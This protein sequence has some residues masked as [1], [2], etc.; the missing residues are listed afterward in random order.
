MHHEVFQNM[1][2]TAHRNLKGF[3]LGLFATVLWGSYYP[4]AR[5]IFGKEADS[6]DPFLLSL[7]RFCFCVLFFLPFVIGS[8]KRRAELPRLIRKEWKMLI[9]LALSGVVVQGVLV[10]ISL[11][12]TTAARG[13]LMA[14]AAPVFTVLLAWMFLKEKISMKM[15]IGMIVGFAGISLAMFSRSQDIFSEITASTLTGDVLALLSGAAW[16]VYTVAGV[17]I[18][19]E[20]DSLTVTML[21]FLI[22]I[23]CMPFVMLVSG[24]TFDFRLS[25]RLWIGMAYMGIFTGG[26]AFCAWLAALRFVESSRL[27]AFGYLSALLA[28][29]FSIIFLKESMSPLFIFSA[30][31]AFAGMYLMMRGQK[32]AGK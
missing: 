24:S 12:Y 9:L 1:D 30:L 14:N 19:R 2:Q 25:A 21:N 11:K 31:M 28:A 23:C 4:V 22:G 5:F 29:F 18:V 27:G 10:F 26:I 20:Y 8:G 13:S 3:G 16:A 17:R 15:L 32:S 7:V 6:A